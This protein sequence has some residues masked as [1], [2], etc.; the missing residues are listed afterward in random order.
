MPS[1]LSSKII[2]L[3]YI[4]CIAILT[5]FLFINPGG[6]KER[7]FPPVPCSKPIRYSLGVIDPRFGLSTST[8]LAVLKQ[9]SDLWSTSASTTLFVYDPKGE[10]KVNFIY[11]E[12]QSATNQ[13]KDLGYIISNDRSSYDDLKLKVTALK[14][15]LTLKKSN[16][17]AKT[18]SFN[19]RSKAYEQQV[20][21]WNAKGGATPEIFKRLQADQ[22][23]LKS[24]SEQLQKLVDEYNK[25]TGE[26]N[27]AIS[28]L[29][30][31]A[32]SLNIKADEANAVS[33]GVEKEFEEGEYR[34]DQN[35]KAIDIYEFDSQERLLRVLAHEFGHALGLEHVEDQKAIMYYLNQD[36]T[37]SLSETDIGELK[38]LC[39][40]E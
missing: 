35:G 18:T 14:N 36:K 32:D 4:S 7:L 29:N 15:S 1:T 40:K 11:D 9:S 27:S 10:V 16:L 25:L 28:V 39:G 19:T 3:F 31:I 8:V 20:N 33:Q 12:R 26:L 38:K 24:E 23:K 22:A 5:Y 2:G 13:L 6:L 34:V 37:V 17:D 30:R 21:E